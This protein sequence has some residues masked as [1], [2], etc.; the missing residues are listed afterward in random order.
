[1]NVW[2]I[3]TAHLHGQFVE[4]LP[5]QRAVKSVGPSGHNNKINI[6]YVRLFGLIMLPKS[7]IRCTAKGISRRPVHRAA[8]IQE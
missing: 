3:G 8:R 6:A 5:A 4:T 7:Q 1:M 2:N